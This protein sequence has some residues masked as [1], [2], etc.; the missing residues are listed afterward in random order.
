MTFG[1]HKSVH[2]EPFVDYLYEF[3]H[4]LSVLGSDVRK[5]II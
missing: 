5:K 2:S 3:W 1:A 4:L